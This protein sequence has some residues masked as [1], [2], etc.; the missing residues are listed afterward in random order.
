[1]PAELERGGFASAINPFPDM[2]CHGRGK[3]KS[4]EVIEVKS[5]RES[6]QATGIHLGRFR[7]W[8][9]R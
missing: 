8:G 1:M 3:P 2:V 6:K 7:V 4:V 9:F 5:G